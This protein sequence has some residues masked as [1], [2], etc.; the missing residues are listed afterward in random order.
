MMATALQ[1]ADEALL[2]RASVEFYRQY[3]INFVREIFNAHPD[4]QQQWFLQAVAENDSVAV[5]SGHGTGKTTCLAWLIM[6]FLSLWYGSRAVATAPTQRQL[7]DILWPEIFRW[8]S[9]SP[10]ESMMRWMAT[11]L[12]V[13]GYEQTWFATLR[14]SNKPENVQGFHADHLLIV[15]DEAPGIPQETLEAVEGARTT[16]GSKIVLAGNPTKISGTFYD[17]FHKMRAFYRTQT[18]SSE[19]SRLVTREYCERLAQKYGSDSDFYRVRVLGE[20]P[21]SEPDVLIR[22]DIVQAAIIREDA[23]RSGIVA[24]GVDPARYGD[25]ETVIYWREG[26]YVHEPIVKH[27]ID[28]MWTAGEVA[29]L[30]REIRA[31]IRYSD[32]IP[33][34]VDVTGIGAGVV[35]SLTLQEQELWI[36]VV[37][38]EFGGAGDEVYTNTASLMLGTVNDSLE[39]MRLP[40]DDDTI[41]QL[42]TRK[43]RIMPDG[44]IKI[45]SKDEMRQRGSVSPDRADALGLCFHS[46]QIRVAMSDSTRAAL[47]KR[48]AQV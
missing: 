45:E 16:T 2:D 37:P 27:G 19:S 11:R 34:M 1:P 3:P 15:A 8:L 38:V 31:E 29:R 36:T 22:L 7:I 13:R 18:M 9:G 30:V 17:A 10:L 24:I 32:R 25:S 28:T 12:V 48:R 33:V 6:W 4:P 14:T 20:F 41:A 5:K 43:Y 35:D 39:L 44:K 46:G 23:D 26:Y 40:D 47:R 42:T 21:R